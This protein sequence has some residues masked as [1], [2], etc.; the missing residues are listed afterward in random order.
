VE[1]VYT[2]DLGSCFLYRFAGSSPVS[3]TTALDLGS[4]Y[5]YMRPPN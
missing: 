5:T 3:R 4:K 2:Q 1:L